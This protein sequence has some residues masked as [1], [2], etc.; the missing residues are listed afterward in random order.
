MYGL[1][2]GGSAFCWIDIGLGLVVEDTNLLNF[3]SYMHTQYH[4]YLAVYTC[5]QKGPFTEA[6]VHPHAIMDPAVE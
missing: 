6:H 1:L 3:T 4:V 2:V 5:M